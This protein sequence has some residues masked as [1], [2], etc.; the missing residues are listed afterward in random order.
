[1]NVFRDRHPW[2]FLIAV[3]LLALLAVV[4]SHLDVGRPSA[5][6]YQTF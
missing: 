5:V 6:V 2:L 3:V 4:S 1:M